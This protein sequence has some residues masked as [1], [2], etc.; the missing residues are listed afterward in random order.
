MLH[1]AHAVV[2]THEQSITVQRTS[3]SRA[4]ANY[5]DRHGLCSAGGNKDS[6]HTGLRGV[7]P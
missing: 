1:G 3:L 6:M 7:T 2:L 4:P 5:M